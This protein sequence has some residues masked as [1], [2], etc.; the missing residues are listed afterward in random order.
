MTKHNPD[1]AMGIDGVPPISHKNQ[2]AEGDFADCW[3]FA[4]L[5]RPNSTRAAAH[6]AAHIS[7]RAKV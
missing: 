6:S 2:S 3:T 4:L 7:T 1:H 5:R